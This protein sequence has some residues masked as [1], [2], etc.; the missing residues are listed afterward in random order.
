MAS[1]VSGDDATG[2]YEPLMPPF[3]DLTAAHQGPILMVIS[4]PLLVI[5]TLTVIV[6]LWTVYGIT[7]KLGLSEIAIIAAIV[8]CQYLRLTRPGL[9]G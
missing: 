1:E 8:S 4:I 3:Q 7:R 6:K 5:A 2:L 9:T